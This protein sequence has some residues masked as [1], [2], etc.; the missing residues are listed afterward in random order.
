MTGKA[1]LYTFRFP[2]VNPTNPEDRPTP[3]EI[4]LITRFRDDPK[5]TELTGAHGVEQGKVFYLAHPIRI[6][7]P[8]CLDLP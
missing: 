7:D 3:F 2:T 1:A 6:E 8:Q 4:E 5:L